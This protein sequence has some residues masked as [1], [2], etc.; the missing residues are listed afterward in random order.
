MIHQ[1]RIYEIFEHNK[2][3]FHERFSK[4]ALRIWQ[5]YGFKLVAAWESQNEGWTEFIYLLEWPDEATMRRAWER[6]RGDEEWT[7]I[8]RV[9][10]AQYGELVGKIDEKVLTP[11]DYSPVIQ[12]DQ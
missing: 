8:K 3:A 4:H 6:F 5:P 1:L 10:N 2:A 7:E 9:M 12:P 11:T